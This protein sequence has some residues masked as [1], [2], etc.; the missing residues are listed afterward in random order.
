MPALRLS[1]DLTFPP[2]T[3]T[4]I[5]ASPVPDIL[6]KGEMFVFAV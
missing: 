4:K 1:F 2:R 3:E 6:R 5:A